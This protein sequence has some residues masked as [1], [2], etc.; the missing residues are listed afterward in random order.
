[1]VIGKTESDT[2]EDGRTQRGNK[3]TEGLPQ[4]LRE[5]GGWPGIICEVGGRLV[6]HAARS[7]SSA[8]EEISRGSPQATRDAVPVRKGDVGQESV[9]AGDDLSD[10]TLAVPVKG[11]AQVWMFEKVSCV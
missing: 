9:G 8:Q 10:R 4:E 3:P 7:M 11:P 1:M 2:E 6:V 5:V